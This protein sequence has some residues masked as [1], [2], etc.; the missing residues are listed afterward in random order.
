MTLQSERRR[1]RAARGRGAARPARSPARPRAFA[2]SVRSETTG[3]SGSSPCASTWP[4]HRAPVSS[5][6][7]SVASAAAWRSEVRVDA[8]LPAV[9]ALGAQRMPLGAAQDAD[10]LEV[11]GLEQDVR[12]RLPDL[13]VLA[14]H[15]PGERDRALGVGDDEILGVELAR[16]RRRACGTPRPC[17]PGAR[18]S[19][20]RA[21][22]SKSKACSGLPRASM[23]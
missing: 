2:R 1:T 11:G 17:A 20:R 10:R 12:R 5:T 22:V 3:G 6:M 7:S 19:A 14:A 16:V 15:D 18:R 21:S 13:G 9:R 4:V 23:T 8:L